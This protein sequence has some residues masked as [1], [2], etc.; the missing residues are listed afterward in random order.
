[1]M[2]LSTLYYA[3]TI[4]WICIVLVHRSNSLEGRHVAPL[5]HII[6]M[7]NYGGRSS[8]LAV[9]TMIQLCDRHM[10]GHRSIKLSILALGI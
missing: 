7:P 5:G 10:Y 9:N 1:M 6:L 2:M 3:N 4:S 8:M